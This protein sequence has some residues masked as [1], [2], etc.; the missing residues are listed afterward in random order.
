MPTIE[1]IC[2]KKSDKYGSIVLISP[3]AKDPVRKIILCVECFKLA[4][5]FIESF[6]GRIIR[7]R[8]TY[9]P[10]KAEGE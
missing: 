6:R 7:Q 2:G 4:D 8:T 9:P 1:C 5:K 3:E 10:A